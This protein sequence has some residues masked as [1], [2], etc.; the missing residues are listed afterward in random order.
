MPHF[1]AQSPFDTSY[2][3]CDRSNRPIAVE[4]STEN[5]D[6]PMPLTVGR[7]QRPNLWYIQDI[8]TGGHSRSDACWIGAGSYQLQSLMP[9]PMAGW[10]A[11]NR[12]SS[13]KEDA[14]H[15]STVIYYRILK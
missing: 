6:A 9:L 15:R 7:D 5:N 8:R 10:Q 13:S 11:P 2:R 14:L 12:I 3:K 1:P 4:Q